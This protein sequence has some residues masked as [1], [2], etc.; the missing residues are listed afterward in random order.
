[1]RSRNGLERAAVIDFDV[2]HGNGTE[3][4]FAG[5]ERVVMVGTFE[6]P[7]YPYSGVDPLGPN[8]HNVPLRAG[9]GSEAFRAAMTEVCLPALEAHRPEILFISAGFDAHREDPL[10]NLQF[11]E[12]DYAWVTG[13][14]VALAA[15]HAEGRIVS[16]A[17]RRLR[18]VAR[19]GAAPPSTCARSAAGSAGFSACSD[20]NFSPAA[21][22]RSA[23]QA[24]ARCATRWASAPPHVYGRSRLVDVHGEPLKAS[25]PCPP[26]PTTCST[27]PSPA[28]PCFL[29]NLG[30][31]AAGLADAAPRRRRDLS[32]E[33]RR[34]AVAF[35]RRL[36]RDLRAQARLP[37]A[38]SELHPLPARAARRRPTAT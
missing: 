15:R 37:D 31:A 10:A 11:T 26:T 35:D 34:R 1:M 33:R 20:A 17:R 24:S 29:L 28:T 30:R 19:S 7:L 5:D 9:S 23:P 16:A 13:E 27:I 22:W 4:I 36:L 14:L 12:A 3:Q 25:A 32:L 18:A 2:H 8:M 38:R 21:A 6:Y